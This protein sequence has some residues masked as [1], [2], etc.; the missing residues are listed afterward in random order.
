[1]LE[2]PDRSPVVLLARV[3]LLAALGD[4]LT[5]QVAVLWIGALEPHVSSTVQFGVVHNDQGAYGMSL[6]SYTFHISLALTLATMVLVVPVVRDLAR[7]DR[8]APVALGLIAG[9]ATGNFVS[10]VMSPQGVV[11]FIAVQRADGAGIVLN[12][13]DVA[14]Y[15]GVAMLM[16]TVT[17]VVAEIRRTRAQSADAKL[18]MGR[19][20]ALARLADVEVPR[21]VA[22]EPNVVGRGNGATAG[23]V[24]ARDDVRATHL[25]VVRADLIEERPGHGLAA[26]LRHGDG[27]VRAQSPYLRP[28]SH[29]PRFGS[30]R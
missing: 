19:E 23:S 5:K 18:A 1:M 26:R 12:I 25:R 11:D 21:L 28:M 6:G 3:A 7:I 4:L 22:R 16:R 10:L 29:A 20:A 17:R 13:A 8:R 24:C 9:G 2:R 15:A 30:H 14:A 27:G